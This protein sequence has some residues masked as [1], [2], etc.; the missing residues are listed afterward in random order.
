[1]QLHVN[2]SVYMHINAVCIDAHSDRF[3]KALD[4]PQH[5]DIM[6]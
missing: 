5:P 4:S 1:M 3:W 6:I 2:A